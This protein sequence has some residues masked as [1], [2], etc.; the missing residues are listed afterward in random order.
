LETKIA[1]ELFLDLLPDWQIRTDPPIQQLQN[2]IV[3]GA[4]ALPFIWR[5]TSREG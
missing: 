3:F 1:L 2:Q 4:Q 5:S